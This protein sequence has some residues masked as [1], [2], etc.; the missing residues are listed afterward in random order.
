MSDSNAEPTPP[1][2]LADSLVQRVDA[3]TLSELESLRSYVEQRVE[4][5]RAPIEADIE[6]D[7][8]GDVVAVETYGTYA[9]IR[10]HPPEP[11]GPGVNTGIP[12]LY[13]VRREPRPDGTESLHWVYLGDVHDAPHP[14]CRSCGRPLDEDVIACPHCGSEDVARSG[15]VE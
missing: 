5:R 8:A 9:L 13:H 6:A 10:K 11:G 7:A 14:R 12:S 15:G 4:S 1:D 3:L 2:G